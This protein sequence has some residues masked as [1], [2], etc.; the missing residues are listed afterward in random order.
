M[1]RPIPHAT[2][3]ARDTACGPTVT[4]AILLF[5]LLG[6]CACAH[7]GAKA[8]GGQGVAGKSVVWGQWPSAEAAG[9]DAARLEQIRA[10]A[11]KNQSGAVMAVYQGHVLAAWG[12]VNR[13]LE[14]HSVRKS[15]YAAMW[16]IAEAKGLI[17]LNATLESLGVDDVPALQPGEKKARLID[18]LHARSGVYHPAA[19]ASGEQEASLP[20]RGSKQ[21]GSFW[22]YNN[23]DF[24]VAGA[25][26]EKIGGKPIGVLFEEWIARPIGMEDYRPDDVFMVREPGQSQ[27]PALTFRM[28][29]RDLARF[30]QLWLN[31]GRWNGRQVVPAAWI[32]RAS[33]P[34]SE[35]GN[36]GEGYATMWWSYT[37][38]TGGKY[39][40][41]GRMQTLVARGTGGQAVF[42]IPD[43]HLVVVHRGDTDHHR[44]VPGSDIWSMV[45]GIVGAR[46]K[47]AGTAVTMSAVHAQ[48]FA[49]QLPPLEW[50]SA[51]ALEPRVA[52]RLSGQYEFKPGVVGTIFVQDGG[53]FAFMP[54]QGEAE[55]FPISSTEFFLRVDPTAKV[56]IQNDDTGRPTTVVFTIRGR[57]F[58]GKRVGGS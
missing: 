42:V 29:T 19:Y 47:A 58:V 20:V 1:K 54:G 16:G 9:F 35:T 23:W 28:S 24:N 39:P 36:P 41:V 22:V 27:W 48:P 18:L 56:R 3:G 2:R 31:Q 50:P 32:A 49:S 57:E 44:G 45:D 14:L 34:A 4:A 37:P 12:D 53:I 6:V 51:V 46:T 25:L 38:E 26:L 21:P 15:L 13:K 7:S 5:T 55:L 33:T 30:G 43:A 52:E 17:D 8:D 11:D 40:N 10:T